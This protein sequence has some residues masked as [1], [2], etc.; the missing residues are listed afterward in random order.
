M[1]LK[2]LTLR[3]RSCFH[4]DCKNLVTAGPS[5]RPVLL[6][7]SLLPV[8]VP[9]GSSSVLHPLI[10]HFFSIPL[11]HIT[12]THNQTLVA[13]GQFS[14]R[15][16]RTTFDEKIKSEAL[17]VKE[18]A[19]S[20]FEDMIALLGPDEEPKYYDRYK[21]PHF[22]ECS[23]FLYEYPELKEVKDCDIPDWAYNEQYTEEE[24]EALEV[25]LEENIGN[26]RYEY[27]SKWD[28]LV[29]EWYKDRERRAEEQ[30]GTDELYAEYKEEEGI[31]ECGRDSYYG[32]CM[33]GGGGR[34]AFRKMY[35]DGNY[36]SYGAWLIAR[37]GNPE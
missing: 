25:W 3:L 33:N 29:E 1:P 7:L 35:G 21:E 4:D 16:M 13:T 6:S 36:H 22:N 9:E 27:E 30:F 37:C 31:Y 18:W 32:Y 28:D 11:F 23:D 8:T 2:L 24:E 15:N 26:L 19:K 34:K 5:A 17:T 10:H 20:D 12:I 14:T